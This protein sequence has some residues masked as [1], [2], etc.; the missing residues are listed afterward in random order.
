MKYSFLD[1]LWEYR[2]RLSFTIFALFFVI[3]TIC[4]VYGFIPESLQTAPE[5]IE[6]YM[7]TTNRV[8][9]ATTSLQVTPVQQK[10]HVVPIATSVQSINY[11]VNQL[12]VRILIPS[13]GV[14]TRISSPTSTA[15]AVLDN[16]LLRGAVRYPGSGV[17]GQGNVFIFAHSTGLHVVNNQA[18][19]AFNNFKQLSPG[20]MIIVHSLDK[21]YVYKVDRMR[22]ADADEVYVDLSSTKNILTLSTCNTFGKKEERYVVEASFILVKNLDTRV[23]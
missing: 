19:K 16:A 6:Q 23:L 11:G 18:F 7:S 4:A 8:P 5:R 13:I 21:E 14:D 3:Y 2:Y 20:D 22:L 9:I 17:L 15:P 1:F 10:S 12:P